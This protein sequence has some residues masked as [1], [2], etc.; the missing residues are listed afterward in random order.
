MSDGKAKTEVAGTATSSAHAL[1]SGKATTL[2][3]TLKKKLQ[4]IVK[5]ASLIA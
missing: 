3:P 5:I 1:W 2:S 4:N